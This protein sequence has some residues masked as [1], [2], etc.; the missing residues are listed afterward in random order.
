MM[1]LNEELLHWKIK[2]AICKAMRIGVSIP[3]TFYKLLAIILRAVMFYHE[4]RYN[5]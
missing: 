1:R 3:K 2:I 5:F 4:S